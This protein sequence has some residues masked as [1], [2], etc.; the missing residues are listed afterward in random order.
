MNPPVLQGLGGIVSS[1]LELQIS[2]YQFAP[3]SY[4]LDEIWY[5]GS[6]GRLISE[7]TFLRLLLGDSISS[8]I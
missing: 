8:G 4:S 7:Y 3:C 2:W 1:G 6:W 5:Y